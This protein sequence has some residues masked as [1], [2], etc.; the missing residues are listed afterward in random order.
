MIFSSKDL[1]FLKSFVL[2]IAKF[3]TNISL[4]YSTDNLS[5]VFHK[6]IFTKILENTVISFTDSPYGKVFYFLSTHGVCHLFK[7]QPLFSRQLFLP[8]TKPQSDRGRPSWEI[9]GH[10]S[11][12]PL[13]RHWM[14]HENLNKN[15]KI[16]VYTTIRNCEIYFSQ[17]F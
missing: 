1:R 4:K 2:C 9:G 10:F 12:R 13:S 14:R 7:F 5:L 8:F 3:E 17:Q 16:K 6:S 11:R 15:E